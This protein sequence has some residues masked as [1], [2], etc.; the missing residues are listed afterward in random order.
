MKQFDQKKLALIGLKLLERKETIAVAES[1]SSGLLQF[2]LSSIENAAQL[3]QG[4]ITVY[5]TAQKFKHLQVEPVHALAVNAVSQ[6][7]ANQMALH[8]QQMFA[9][10]WGAGITGYASPV[11]ESGGKTYAYFSIAYGREIVCSGELQSDTEKP[12]DAQHYYTEAVITNLHDLLR[13][14]K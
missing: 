4:G 14:K 6:Q 8:V 10:H 7:V 11:P 12:A 3:F 5:N 2:A 1:V 9:S 13:S